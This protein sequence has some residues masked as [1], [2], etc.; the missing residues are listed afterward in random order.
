MHFYGTNGNGSVRQAGSGQRSTGDQMNGNAVMYDAGKI[1]TLG[2]AVDYEN[3]PATAAAAVIELSG[4]EVAVRSVPPMINKR[5]FHISVVLPD[6]SVAV[7]GGQ[8]YP[9]PFSDAQAV[10]IP[11]ALSC[12][13]AGHTAS[14]RHALQIKCLRG[15]SASLGRKRMMLHRHKVTHLSPDRGLLSGCCAPLTRARASAELWDPGTETFTAL[16]PMGAPRTYHSV[17]VLML[18]GRV[19]SGGG[20]LC[21]SCETDHF[22]AHLRA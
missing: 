8:P 14:H 6:G 9:Q 12:D 22:G 4:T 1:L 20:G 3:A 19:F 15:A 2:G 7:F 10:M 5:A 13:V 18:D 17:A 16:A 21:G 11:G